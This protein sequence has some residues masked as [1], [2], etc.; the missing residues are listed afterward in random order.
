GQVRPVLY[1]VAVDTASSLPPGGS[2]DRWRENHK[3]AGLPLIGVDVGPCDANS[4]N[5]GLGRTCIH[6]RCRSYPIVENGSSL[7]LTGASLWDQ[8][9]GSVKFSSVDALPPTPEELQ[10]KPAV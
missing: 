7:V 6:G 10:G 9:N 1:G 8:V 4:C 2:A 5:E 3:H